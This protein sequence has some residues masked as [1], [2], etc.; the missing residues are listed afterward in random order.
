MTCSRAFLCLAL[1]VAVCACGS[2]PDQ[3]TPAASGAVT[4][5]AAALPEPPEDSEMSL[6]ASALVFDKPQEA[7]D[8]LEPHLAKSPDDVSAHYVLAQAYDRK[9]FRMKLDEKGTKAERQQVYEKAAEHY[10]KYASVGK[11]LQPEVEMARSLLPLTM[12]YSSGWLDRPSDVETVAR[13][14]IELNPRDG[15]GYRFLARAYSEG[16]R[17]DEAAA[18]LRKMRTEL[19]ADQLTQIVGAMWWHVQ[20]TKNLSREDVRAVVQDLHLIADDV[21]KARPTDPTGP[22]ARSSALRLEAEYLEPNQQRKQ[23]LLAEAEKWS[24]AFQR[25]TAG[26]A[27]Q[28]LEQVKELQR[29]HQSRTR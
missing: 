8:L 18:L 2:V 7:I 24:A 27:Q 28:M 20:W 25:M 22:E 9:G 19:P 17:P 16:G 21:L 26:E 23:E 10:R 11:G 15:R 4:S 5:P 1:G 14:M 6:T 3:S 29:L 12:L 13:R